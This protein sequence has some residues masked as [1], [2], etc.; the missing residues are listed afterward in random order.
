MS[1]SGRAFRDPEELPSHD[2]RA[3]RITDDTQMTLFTAERLIRALVRAQA[4]GICAPEGVVHHER[5]KR[6]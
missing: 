5:L 6:T 4:R 1:R 3:G 2:G